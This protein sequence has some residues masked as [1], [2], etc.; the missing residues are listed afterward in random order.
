MLSALLSGETCA[1]C[2]NCCIFEEQSAWEVPTFSA[3]AV[4]R[5]PAQ[6]AY[7]V[8]AEGARFRI[9]L[10]YDET[11]TA[12]P[13]PFLNAETGCTLPPEEKP[14][15]CSLWPIR[16]MRDENGTVFFALYQ[17]CPGIPAEQAE[18]VRALLDG[19]LRERAL[20][21]AEQDPSLIL[22]YHANYIRVAE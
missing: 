22:P 11:H 19:G 18:A 3:A 10:P 5:L 6:S 9:T 12:K 20:W 2:K 7:Q 13:C 21:E 8:T 4:R 1:Q 17:G 15:A 16:L 14:F